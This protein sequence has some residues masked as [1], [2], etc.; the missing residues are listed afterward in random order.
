MNAP[1]H[2][3]QWPELPEALRAEIGGELG[4]PV[5]EAVG[6]R[7]GYGPSLAARCG[8]ADGRRVFVKAASPAQNP[9]TPAM[10]RREARIAEC[11]PADAPAPALLHTIDDGEWIALVFE[12]IPGRLPATPWQADE[13]DRVLAATLAL[14]EL[15]PRAP[16]R[17]VAQQYGAMFTGWR[18]LAA[19]A[20]DTPM[21]AWCAHRLDDLAA[22]EA[23]WEDV[24]RGDGLIHGDVRSDNVLLTADGRV[25]FVDWTSTCTGAPWFEVLVM[26]PS[27]ELEGGGAPEAVLR[28]AGLDHLPVD[29]VVPVVAATAGYFVERGRLPDPP[30]L[31]TLR[32]F[33]RAQGELTIAWLRRLW[34]QR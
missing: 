17:T 26:L 23:R 28:R 20:R 19:E 16:L 18:T 5:V 9:D 33:Q 22:A 29:D 13:L 27:I 7:G 31:P 10:M 24:T 8:L 2:R 3:L 6:Q 11:L 25:T 1:G 4:S 15:V 21:D 30:G 14:G 32:A 12:E 34:E